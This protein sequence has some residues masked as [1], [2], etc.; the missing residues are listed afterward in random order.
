MD[1]EVI[2]DEVKPEENENDAEDLMSKILKEVGDEYYISTKKK[3]VFDYFYI[4]GDPSNTYKE[5]TEK[6]TSFTKLSTIVEAF[7][8]MVK[9][10]KNG[11]MQMIL[12]I[13]TRE[14]AKI[15]SDLTNVMG[16]SLKIVD[17]A[18][19]APVYL[20]DGAKDIV[21]VIRNEFT[22]L[23]MAYMATYSALSEA[24]CDI[25]Y[26]LGKFSNWMSDVESIMDKTDL[27]EGSD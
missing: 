21:K 11:Q 15:F 24:D 27:K 1:V 9:E 5:Y 16:K 12:A 23:G 25:E 19:N 6:I 7:S 26:N 13:E 2:N 4:N 14:Q 8:N 20:M 22:N 3:E 17:D 18:L 10:I